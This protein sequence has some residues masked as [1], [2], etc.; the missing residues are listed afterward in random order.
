ME[1]TS[2]FTLKKLLGAGEIIQC[3]KILSVKHDN[4]SSVLD[5]HKD[6]EVN[7]VVL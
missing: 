3:V 1:V 4:L 7:Q 6:K 5:P 2:T